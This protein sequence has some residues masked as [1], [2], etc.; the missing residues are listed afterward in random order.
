MSDGPTD[1]IVV[2]AGRVQ[3]L[4]KYDELVLHYLKAG[5]HREAFQVGAAQSAFDP[6]PV[7][8]YVFR[9]R[10][11]LR[12]NTAC[13]AILWAATTGE[14]APPA[15]EQAALRSRACDLLTEDL[16]FEAK[17]A[18]DLRSG[19]MTRESSTPGRAWEKR[20]AFTE[21]GK[22]LDHWLKDKDL[23][24]VRHPICTGLLPADERDR[25][26]AFWA[27]VRTLRDET[28]AKP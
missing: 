28:A 7:R 14:Q 21:V 15:G 20:N 16:A 24:T 11:T 2:A 18:A 8:N 27:K 25:W 19:R 10:D 1:R 6:V 23:V 26:R 4:F 17:T 12:Y 9:D 13:A 5:K 22:T 3:K